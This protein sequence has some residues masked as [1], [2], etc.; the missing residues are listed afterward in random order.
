MIALRNANKVRR[1]SEG[2]VGEE[3][4]GSVANLGVVGVGSEGVGKGGS[5]AEQKRQ[6]SSSKSGELRRARAGGAGLDSFTGGRGSHNGVRSGQC[7]GG[8]G[9]SAQHRASPAMEEEAE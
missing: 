9:S 8:G 4:Q 5:T 7:R 3:V 1:R 2:E 6:R